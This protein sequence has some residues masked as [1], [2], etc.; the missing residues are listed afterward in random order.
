M[1][2][3]LEKLLSRLY[4]SKIFKLNLSISGMSLPFSLLA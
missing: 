4:R 1:K 2:I 3:L